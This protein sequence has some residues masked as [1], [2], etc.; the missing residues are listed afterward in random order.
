MLFFTLITGFVLLIA[1]GELLVRGGVRLAR[2]IGV[3]PLVIGITI[4]GFGTSTPELVAAIE[5]ALAGVPQL[6]TGNIVGSNIANLLFILGIAALLSPISVTRE[7]VRR[8]GALLVVTAA[9]LLV[10]GLVGGLTRPVGIAFIVA[11][12]AYMWFL[13]RHGRV[14]EEILPDS[15]A[16]PKGPWELATSGVLTLIGIALVITGGKLLVDGAIQLARLLDVSE[17]VIGLTVVAVGTSLPELATTLMAALRKSPDIAL[18]NVLGS[19][20]Y[21]V[22]GIGGITATVRPLPISAHMLRFDLPF[23]VALS[24]LV[25]ALALRY[26]KLGRL[27]GVLFLAG[28][29]AYVASLFG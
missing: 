26:E 12:I 17:Q 20:V 8:D 24:I 2:I 29:A 23:M 18:G 14:P 9:L 13:L 16:T 4:V 6:A 27:T 25:V 22:L 28:Y 15:V 1:G 5:A 7:T 10:A 21:N 11:L 3:P 19:N